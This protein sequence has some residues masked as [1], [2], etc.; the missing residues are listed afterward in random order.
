MHSRKPWL[1]LNKLIQ[2][3]INRDEIFLA[4]LC[5]LE[6]LRLNCKQNEIFE[7]ARS[8]TEQFKIRFPDRL[9]EDRITVS[10]IMPT[11]RESLEI[12]EAVQSVLNQTFQDFE[13][14]VVNDGGPREIQN[15]V[16]SF[17]SNKI[18]YF[19]LD[20]RAGPGAARN[21]GIL[22]ALG[23]YLAYLDDD[24]V[25]YPHHL[26]TLVGLLKESQSKFGYTNMVKIIGSLNQGRFKPNRTD[27]V[28]DVPFD[29]GTMV[30]RAYMG[31]NTVLHEKG[32]LEEI[33]L[34]N[35]KLFPGEDEDLWIRCAARYDFKHISQCTSE[36]RRKDDNSVR[37]H[38]L[39]CAFNGLLY[40]K[41]YAFSRGQIAFI[42]CFL[43]QNDEKQA[44]A[45]YQGIKKQYSHSFKT[46]FVVEQ[47]IKIAR[48]F[49]DK[50]FLKQLAHDYRHL[51]AGHSK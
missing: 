14:I 6:S 5:S 18:R 20:H 16:E 44:D 43:A 48:H 31:T 35:E 8:L 23:K 47:V 28:W 17:R 24:D 46:V 34:F 38:V 11:N 50:V 27:T 7:R 30:S 36:Y 40:R 37:L 42:K 12:K 9:L 45:L 4:L 49:N 10:V 22:E 21:Q 29:R 33:G 32:I 1:A 26:E 51:S 15:T 13:L 3:Y 25:Y 39:D 41:Y 19:R 2:I